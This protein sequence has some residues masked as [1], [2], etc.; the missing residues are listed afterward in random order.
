[1]GWL[2]ARRL[3]DIWHNAVGI[4]E[5]KQNKKKTYF[6][7]KFIILCFDYEKDIGAR[8][9]RI[10]YL[11]WSNVTNNNKYENQLVQNL[12]GFQPNRIHKR[13]VHLMRVLLDKLNILQYNRKTAHIYIVRLVER[14]HFKLL[15]GNKSHHFNNHE[16][17]HVSSK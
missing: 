5:H 17:K 6:L 4:V 11:I 7:W 2:Q 15:Y 12:L 14:L 10:W 9:M 13:N 1:M 3:H 16:V 8:L